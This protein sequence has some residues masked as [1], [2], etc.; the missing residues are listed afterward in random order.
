VKQV[1]ISLT[2]DQREGLEKWAEAGRCSLSEEIRLRL[3]RTL[4]DDALGFEAREF[5]RDMM[6][7]AEL[8]FDQ[9]PYDDIFPILHTDHHVHR[10]LTVAVNE[11]LEQIKPKTPVPT[12]A[13]AD[14]F[15][16]DT[17]G[18]VAA[19][20]YKRLKAEKARL[21]RQIADKS[22]TADEGSDE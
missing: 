19:R 6:W 5:G 21:L 13:A 3:A 1:K 9:K 11:W 12:G 15:D 14:L 18:H 17:W 4:A 20:N 22:K 8:V 2:D 10:A 7:I 16:P